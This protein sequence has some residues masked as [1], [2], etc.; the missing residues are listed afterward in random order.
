MISLELSDI[1]INFPVQHGHGFLLDFNCDDVAL[2]FVVAPV[3]FN[4]TTILSEIKVWKRFSINNFITKS[5]DE[6]IIL[7]RN[8]GFASK[9]YLQETIS[10]IL[11]F[12][13]SRY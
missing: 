4:P 9:G 6:W 10:S 12:L 11:V 7:I 3:R 5:Q 13:A 1:L 8:K 2:D